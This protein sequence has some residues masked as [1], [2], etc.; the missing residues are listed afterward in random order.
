MDEI[1][2]G[3][4]KT[5]LVSARTLA[6]PASGARPLRGARRPACLA[7]PRPRRSAAL[8][9]YARDPFGPPVQFSGR[10]I[11]W[12][13]VQDDELGAQA[14]RLARIDVHAVAR[15]RGQH[16]AVR[17]VAG[18]E[19]RDVELDPAVRDDRAFVRGTP[20]P[21]ATGGCSTSARSR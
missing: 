5:S 10:E 18:D 7:R 11:D 13:A 17:A 3:D 16:E 4:D 14:R 19:R 15:R 20:R 6:A 8:G 1:T 21:A 12:S 9:A 2:A